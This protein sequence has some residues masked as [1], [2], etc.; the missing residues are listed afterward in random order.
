MYAARNLQSSQERLSGPGRRAP[1][2]PPPRSLLRVSP[3]RRRVVELPQSRSPTPSRSSHRPG[4][5]SARASGKRPCRHLLSPERKQATW[6]SAFVISAASDP[7]IPSATQRALAL[8]APDERSPREGSRP[9]W[10]D[11]HDR[12]A[13]PTIAALRDR[14]TIR[15]RPRAIGHAPRSRSP[16]VPQSR[17]AGR[18]GERCAADRDFSS[19][20]ATIQAVAAASR[21]QRRRRGS[22]VDA[23]KTPGLRARTLLTS[24]GRSNYPLLIRALVCS[25]VRRPAPS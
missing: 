13:D 15:I 24:E 21:P 4:F 22:V 14:R 17:N 23:G 5:V 2:R 12:L 19:E 10:P 18:L 20:P 7:A 11:P 3:A 9:A 1:G 25:E 6:A 8:P 16:T